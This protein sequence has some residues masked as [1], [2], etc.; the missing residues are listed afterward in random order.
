[1]KSK[2]KP[3]K[4]PNLPMACHLPSA[5]GDKP[6]HD[7][8]RWATLFRI[9]TVFLA[10]VNLAESSQPPNVVLIY[11]DDQGSVDLGCYGSDDLLIPHT[12]R[13]AETG[14]RFTTM[15]A[16]A[17]ICSASRAA[18]LTGRYPATVGVPGNVGRDGRG[19]LS[20]KPTIAHMFQRAGYATALIGKWHLGH[21]KDN[22][23][24]ANGF[25]HFFGHL[26]GC[27]DNYS[28]FFYWSGPNEHDLWRNGER[29]VHDGSYFPD[30]VIDEAEAF[31]DG[32]GGKPFFIY[33]AMNTPHYPYQDE[34]KW[35]QHYRDAGIPY[36]RDLYNAF[37]SSQDERI[38]RLV[39]YLEARGLREN[40]I[41]IFQSDHGH[42]VEARAHFGGG[43]AGPF[44]GSKQSLF[45]GGLRVPS[46][47]S[48]PGRLPE[49][50]VRNQMVHAMDWL[51]TLAGLCGIEPVDEQ[52]DG[53]SMVGI[54]KSEDAREIHESLFW[55]FRRNQWAVRQGPWKLI[56]NPSN[57][58]RG[59]A[60]PAEDRE[61]FLS[62]LDHDPGERDNLAEDHPE[63]VERLKAAR[64]EWARQP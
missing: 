31:I 22:S 30:L 25:D 19:G 15:Y 42:S 39:T 29:A 43:S 41:L 32:N 2:V 11:T 36:P 51:P 57:P 37:V 61:W 12:D 8:S 50:E 46:I 53:R 20:G 5:R 6:L 14:V 17:P 21:G 40:T 16:P 28:H 59:D 58:V 48:Y 24:M 18:L 9:L 35:V 4:L 34:E 13:L 52:I 27:I 62:R 64:P 63:V 10:A 33:L 56:R 49:N 47:I 26:G 44:R 7:R 60:L 45:E 1:M 54:L 38:G 23:P 55:T 3:Y